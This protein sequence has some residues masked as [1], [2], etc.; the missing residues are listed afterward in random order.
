[1]HINDNSFIKDIQNDRKDVLDLITSVN[2]FREGLENEF[3]E[4]WMEDE[5]KEE[6]NGEAIEGLVVKN[7]YDK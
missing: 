6:Q 3:Q 4:I 7:L 2:N 1:M 5:E